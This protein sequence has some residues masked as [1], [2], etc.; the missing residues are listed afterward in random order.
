[1]AETTDDFKRTWDGQPISKEPPYGAMIVVYR[2]T[3]GPAP[4]FL[5]LHRA[6]NGPEFDGDW[7][8]G[9]PG[10]ARY[11]G[12]AIDV[13]AARE[14][15]EETGLPLVVQCVETESADWLVYLAEAPGDADIQLSDEHD[16]HVWLQFDE[17][18]TCI[19][20]EMVRAQFIAAAR[21]LG[22]GD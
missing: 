10:G 22:R 13:C 7:A 4:E 14:L 16:R 20:P 15:L 19:A 5:L 17:A 6:H 9:P 21:C 3:T 11:P 18:A 2:R 1:M 8:W 12:E